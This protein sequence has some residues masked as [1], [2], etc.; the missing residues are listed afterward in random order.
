MGLHLDSL[1]VSGDP[2]GNTDSTYSETT[3]TERFRN[4]LIVFRDMESPRLVAYRAKTLHVMR[5]EK[6]ASKLNRAAICAAI[7]ANLR[8]CHAERVVT[9][10]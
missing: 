8:H 7:L 4:Q 1:P 9:T 3:L 5:S 10:S 2:Q 6:L